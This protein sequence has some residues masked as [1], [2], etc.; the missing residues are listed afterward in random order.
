MDELK[1]V[2]HKEF[3]KFIKGKECEEKKN[4]TLKDLKIKLDFKPLIKKRAL[5][6]SLD[7]LE[8]IKPALL[9]RRLNLLG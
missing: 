9:G 4:Y 6:V 8:L 5:V 2:S 3:N 7:D 1:L